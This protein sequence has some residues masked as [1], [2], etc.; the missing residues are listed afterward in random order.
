MLN[1]ILLKLRV[2]LAVFLSPGNGLLGVT[3][4]FG[5]VLD[6]DGILLNG[7]VLGCEC[8]GNRVEGN[9]NMDIFVVL[10]LDSL[11]QHGSAESGNALLAVND[12]LFTERLGTIIV[13]RSSL[14]RLE[15]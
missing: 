12:N 15:T 4:D 9:L 5:N 10:G 1:V 7:G 11:A 13:T 8:T 3:K 14:S 6:P 2:L